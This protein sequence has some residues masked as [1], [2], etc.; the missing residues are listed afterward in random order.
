MTTDAID[1]V[2]HAWAARYPELDTS[3]LDVF[4]RIRRIAVLVQLESDRVLAVHNVSRAD[5]DIL[6]ALARSQRPM[7]P[8]E[9]ATATLTSAPGTTKRLQRLVS[10]G[11]VVRTPNPDDG[12]GALIELTSQADAIVLP[13]LKGLSA[14]EKG[15]LGAVSAS[16][17]QTLVQGLR[18]ILGNVEAVPDA[19]QNSAA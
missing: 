5:F 8:T 6:S 17:E 9:I 19:S 11:M 12:R 4:G 3:P 16:D 1:D 10:V 13:I 14:L 18:G 2:R 7:T 15:L